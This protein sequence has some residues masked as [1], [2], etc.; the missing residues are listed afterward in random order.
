MLWARQRIAES[1][2]GEPTAEG[3]DEDQQPDQPRPALGRRPWLAL[4]RRARSLRRFAFAMRRESVAR[5]RTNLTVRDPIS[6]WTTANVTLPSSC[7]ERLRGVKVG[8]RR[9]LLRGGHVHG[10]GL[11]DPLLVIGL[12]SEGRVIDTVLV[13]PGCFLRLRGATWVLELPDGY[14][15][16]VSGARLDLYA[17]QGER[18]ADPVRNTHRQ[19]R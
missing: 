14:P 18:Q 12:D 16:P 13:P 15:H 3:A 4:L 1:R 6:G 2:K 11:D 7:L 9:V 19:S 17:R 10:R 5:S 8:T